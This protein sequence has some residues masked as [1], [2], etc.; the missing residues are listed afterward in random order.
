MRNR[1]F[2]TLGLFD[3]RLGLGLNWLDFG[4]RWGLGRLLEKNHLDL[5]ARFEGNLDLAW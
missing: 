2:G 5:A 1:V 4:N 3:R